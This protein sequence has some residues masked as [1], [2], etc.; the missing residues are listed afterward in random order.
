MKTI[1]DVERLVKLYEDEGCNLNDIEFLSMA[2]YRY[3]TSM[4]DCQLKALLYKT[5]F[6][7][8]ELLDR[9]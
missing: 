6:L 5:S 2:L 8:K 9:K 1:E 7:L 3:S 4:E